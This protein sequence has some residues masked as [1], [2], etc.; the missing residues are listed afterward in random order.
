M[1]RHD[2]PI[3]G[4]AT[5]GDLLVEFTVGSVDPGVHSR[6]AIRHYEIEDGSAKRTDPLALSPSDFVDEW[7]TTGW[8]ES[9]SWS[10][11][12]NRRSMV[13]WRR[14][15]KETPTESI[16]P[17]MHCSLKPD[18]WQVAIDS[19]GPDTVHPKP[20]YF[21]VRWR[22]PYQF[23]MVAVAEKP[24]PDCREKDAAADQDRTLFPVQD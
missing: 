24:W 7:L 2:P 19:S 23:R 20:R 22:P 8:K 13:T 11:S 1:G 18:L 6:E 3:Q 9:A 16:L 5:T 14:K 10:E 21:L 17:T 4:S 12:T 15:L